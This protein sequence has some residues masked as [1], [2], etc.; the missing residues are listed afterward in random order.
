MDVKGTIQLTWAADCLTGAADWGIGVHTKHRSGSK[1]I[2]R[3]EL[4]QVWKWTPTHSRIWY[5]CPLQICCYMAPSSRRSSWITQGGWWWI[6]VLVWSSSLVL[7]WSLTCLTS[8]DSTSC[9]SISVKTVLKSFISTLE[10]TWNL[11]GLLVTWLLLNLTTTLYYIASVVKC[12]SSSA[13]TIVAD[14]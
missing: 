8:T 7:S 10:K 5:N 12:S 11:N 1:I 13:A 4:Y 9:L 14:K 6:A 2:C 3:G